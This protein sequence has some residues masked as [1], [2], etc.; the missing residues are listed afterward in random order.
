MRYLPTLFTQMLFT[1]TLLTP[2]LL[3]PTLFMPTLAF[4]LGG[5]GSLAAQTSEDHA[6]TLLSGPPSEWPA[7][8]E[9]LI[10]VGG[11][12]VEFIWTHTV[13]SFST[14]GR[15]SAGSTREPRAWGAR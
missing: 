4:V 13:R 12:E 14:P 1:Q 11:R 3:T 5:V 2:T 9:G 10:D 6:R 7:A 8:V 15:G